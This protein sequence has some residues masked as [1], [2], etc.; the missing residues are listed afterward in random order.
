MAGA[1]KP[2]THTGLGRLRAHPQSG[3][4][5]EIGGALRAGLY[6][7]AYSAMDAD[8]WRRVEELYH[9]A[10]SL[11]G[12]ARTRFLSQQCARDES[13]RS[14]VESLLAQSDQTWTPP[15]PGAANGV[16][17]RTAPMIGRRVGGYQIAAP[18]RRGRDGRS[19]SRARHEAR[20]RRR[21]Q[22]PAAR[23]H[24]RPGAARA[25]RARSADAGRAQSSAHRRDLRRRG[26]RRCPSAGAGAGRGR[27]AGRSR[28]QRGPLPVAEA[29]AI[30]RQ[31]AD[32]LEAAHEKGI[33]HRDLKPANIKVTP[34]GVVK[35]LDFGLAKAVP[36]TDRHPTSSQSPTVTVGGTREG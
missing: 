20:A 27:D 17:F 25:L 15:Y 21:D 31:I 9:A 32:A 26:S 36:A 33:I 11:A 35:V 29:L 24:R 14:E 7:G 30:A 22:D 1:W 23:L 19:V 12:D 3:D 18:A 5:G 34:D 8:R 28:W 13:L 10:R 6:N 4:G 16:D 2:A